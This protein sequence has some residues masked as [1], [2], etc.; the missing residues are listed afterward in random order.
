MFI[1]KFYVMFRNYITPSESSIVIKVP[2]SYVGKPLEITVS[3]LAE[4]EPEAMPKE[5]KT[6]AAFRGSITLEEAAA[7]QLHTKES[8]EEWGG[9]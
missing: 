6:M 5:A 1:D 4:P 3:N 8:R 7:L 9:I 2:D